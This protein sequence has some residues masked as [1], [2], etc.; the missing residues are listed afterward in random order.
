M[1]MEK[2]AA[3]S[4]ALSVYLLDAFRADGIVSLKLSDATF[5][6]VQLTE[7][8]ADEIWGSADGL[9]SGLLGKK[10]AQREQNVTVICETKGI[11]FS[12]D[13]SVVFMQ[14]ENAV[15]AAA[16]LLTDKLRRWSG[17]QSNGKLHLRMEPDG[18]TIVMNVMAGGAGFITGAQ[19]SGLKTMLIGDAGFYDMYQLTI[20][21]GDK[22]TE[23]AVSLLEDPERPNTWDNHK[24]G[25]FDFLSYAGTVADMWGIS[26][27]GKLE[28][29]LTPVPAKGHVLYHCRNIDGIEYEKQF[30]YR[31]ADGRTPD[32]GTDSSAVISYSTDGDRWE[33]LMFTDNGQQDASLPLGDYYLKIAPAD[34]KGSVTIE[35]GL[36][37]L[38]IAEW[39]GPE[40]AVRVE[41]DRTYGVQQCVITVQAED[42]SRK[43]KYVILIVS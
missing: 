15:R 42:T 40:T 29:A 21:D 35:S 32:T 20:S 28:D 11:P 12:K 10:N 24:S 3:G 4:R 43:T 18:E 38:S 1:R 23:A 8:K 37:G 2:P 36:T 5:A 34:A 31:L 26:V 16:D 30:C 14:D 33:T 13:Y 9:L 6:A 41:Y 22:T 17:G 7:E 25:A 39:T 19:G 27:S